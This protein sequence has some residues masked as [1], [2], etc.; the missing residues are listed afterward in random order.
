MKR[1]CSNCDNSADSP[2]SN[3]LPVGW[4]W[5]SET[6]AG[7]ENFEDYARLLCGICHAATELALED[8]RRRD[9]VGFKPVRE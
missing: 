4:R 6:D 1:Y 3:S 7:D 5:V 2:D 8:V 9:S